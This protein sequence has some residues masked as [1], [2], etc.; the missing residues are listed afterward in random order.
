MRSQILLTGLPVLLLLF[1]ACSAGGGAQ[2]TTVPAATVEYGLAGF[3]WEWEGARPEH[4][5]LSRLGSAL[6]AW[7][8]IDLPLRSRFNETQRLHET[9]FA[10]GVALR[11]GMPRTASLTDPAPTT[12]AE[13]R[14]TAHVQPG[15]LDARQADVLLL[16]SLPAGAPELQQAAGGDALL[17]DVTATAVFSK[18]DAERLVRLQKD[19]WNGWY[20]GEL[21]RPHGNQLAREVSAESLPVFW[22]IRGELNGAPFSIALTQQT[23]VFSDLE[24]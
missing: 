16:F 19:N 23:K 6:A 21:A 2:L 9:R 4:E 24:E 14:A 18:P 22:T 11:L 7:N 1:A 10:D 20:T 3:G 13:V 5:A 8:F 17:E 12:W 15:A